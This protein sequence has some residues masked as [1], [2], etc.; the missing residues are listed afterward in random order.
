M[1]RDTR[2]A[3]TWILEFPLNYER[4]VPVVSKV[5]G[6]TCYGSLDGSGQEGSYEEP[7][8]V[9]KLETPEAFVF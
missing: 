6:A 3:S 7:M 1:S 4:Q 2:S 5:H 8:A 9:S